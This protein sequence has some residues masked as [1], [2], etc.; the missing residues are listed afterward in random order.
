MSEQTK[1]PECGGIVI[2]VLP[3]PPK[4]PRACLRCQTCGKEFEWLEAEYTERWQDG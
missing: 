4:E 3:D 2:P 1:C